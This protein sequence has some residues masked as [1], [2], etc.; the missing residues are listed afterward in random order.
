[1][2]IVRSNRANIKN[3]N[4]NNLVIFISFDIVVFIVNDIEEFLN[5]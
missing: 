1:M 5:I 4:V 2:N 3:N